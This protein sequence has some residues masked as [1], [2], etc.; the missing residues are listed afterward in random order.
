MR[1]VERVLQRGAQGCI[2]VAPKDR[3]TGTG[4]VDHGKGERRPGRFGIR[5][6]PRP[7]EA[8]FL[9]S[10]VRWNV[11]GRLGA[12][13][14]EPGNTKAPPAAVEGPAVVA[15]LEQAIAGDPSE[16]E[17]VVAVTTPVEDDGGHAARASEHHERSVHKCDGQWSTA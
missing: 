11:P 6:P 15:A 7:H 10:R 5:L 3:F 9:H 1:D 14:A 16:R 17:R 2:Q 8:V 13:V 12:A 4:T